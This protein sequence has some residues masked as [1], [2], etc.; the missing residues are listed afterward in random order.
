MSSTLCLSWILTYFAALAAGAAGTQTGS[1]GQVPFISRS[2][3]LLV[4]LQGTWLACAQEPLPDSANEDRARREHT[5]LFIT[6]NM[7]QDKGKTDPPPPGLG[8]D[9]PQDDEAWQIDDTPVTPTYM[10][11]GPTQKEEV[12][13]FFQQNVDLRLMDRAAEHGWISLMETLE[14]WF[15][16]GREVDMALCM[17]VAR[18]QD[19]EDEDYD[20]WA[21]VPILDLLHGRMDLLTSPC[22]ETSP[23]VFVQW[24]TRVEQLL[25]SAYEALGQAT[26]IPTP[27]QPEGN[28][29]DGGEDL[30]MVTTPVQQHQAW[31]ASSSSSG[32]NDAGS[33]RMVE[34]NDSRCDNEVDE[35]G[36]LEEAHGR[37]MQLRA[38]GQGKAARDALKARLGPL[39][40]VVHQ[41]ATRTLERILS[42]AAGDVTTRCAPAWEGGTVDDW[43]EYVI[44]GW[45]GI[46][47]VVCPPALA[48]GEASGSSRADAPRGPPVPVQAHMGAGDPRGTE[49]RASSE[50][51]GPNSDTDGGPSRSRSPAERPWTAREV[52]RSLPRS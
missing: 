48:S 46:A 1:P 22:R 42:V 14:E 17:V 38:R 2:S 19:R 6:D 11:R 23:P 39:A 50:G 33:S 12:T 36:W 35:D 37:Y 20:S 24:A 29:S 9:R 27:A 30:S 16:E 15:V 10:I 32:P 7:I 3:L 41:A 31:V 18:V 51:G 49:E 43:V 47:G 4:P 44:R 25:W 45:G 26:D 52:T 5:H 8:H 28:A 40:S 13:S 21:R 34:R